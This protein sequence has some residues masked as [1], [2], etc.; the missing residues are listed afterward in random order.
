MKPIITVEGV[1]KRY[2]IG[3]KESYGSLSDDVMDQ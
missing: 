1:S 2:I 3:K